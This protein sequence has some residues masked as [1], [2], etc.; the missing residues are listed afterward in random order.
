[1]ISRKF[2]GGL[3]VTAGL[4][5]T[6]TGCS[7]KDPFGI[8]YDSSSCE[9]SKN[10]GACGSPKDLYKN[11]DLIRGVQKDYIMSGIED[12]LFFAINNEGKMLVKADRDDK[13][14][15]YDGSKFKKDIESRNKKTKDLIEGESD[16]HKS[17]QHISHDKSSSRVISPIATY[18]NDIPVTDET[19][20]SIKYKEQGPLIVSRTKVGDI[21]RDNGLIQQVFVA[22]YVDHANDLIASHEMYVVVKDPEWIVGEKT[23]KNVKI[24]KMPTPISTK[25]ITDEVKTTKFQEDVVD[26]Y[27]SDDKE[28][29]ISVMTMDPKVEKEKNED[30]D[31][32][33]SFLNSN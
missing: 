3:A 8:G 2:L 10:F 21:I 25:L 26:S 33:N 30:T 1:M 9:D 14:M 27:N 20:L 5:F 6:M 7:L 13:W 29:L 4:L 18:Q 22:N 12:E 31:L 11:R 32:I 28:G 17:S 15:P 23:P 24:D 16:Q 19:D